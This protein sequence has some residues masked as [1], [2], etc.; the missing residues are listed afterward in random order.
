MAKSELGGYD[1]VD[2]VFGLS[3]AAADCGFMGVL[4]FIGSPGTLE[5]LVS[6]SADAL[7]DTLR[8]ANMSLTLP[9]FC[10]AIFPDEA[11]VILKIPIDSPLSENPPLPLDPILDAAVLCLA[12]KPPGWQLLKCTSNLP[13]KNPRLQFGQLTLPCSM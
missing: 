5:S 6:L 1:T 8:S 12:K 11:D 13:C 4:G 2:V 9:D 7:G 3:F 10:D